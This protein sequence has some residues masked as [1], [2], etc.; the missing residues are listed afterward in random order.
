M[1][2]RSVLVDAGRLYA[3]LFRRS[4]ATTTAVY[5]PIVAIE[6]SWEEFTDGGA[7]GTLLGIVWFLALIAGP[8]VVQGALVELVDDVH[9]G[10]RPR[11]TAALLR[12]TTRRLLSLA[13]AVIAYSLAVCLGLV[14]LVVPGLY[15]LARWSLVVPAVMLEDA[16][17]GEAIDRS[18]ELVE[19]RTLRVLVV[20]LVSA[21]VEL[22]L[23]E[24]ALW[25]PVCYVESAIGSGVTY[26]AV[27]VLG[28]PY[29]AHLLNV[30]YYRLAQPGRPLLP[31]QLALR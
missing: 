7:P 19:G 26:Y 30:L 6:I 21:T 20:V 5:I 9:E 12:Q 24:L 8:L 10:S 2:P 1:S 11:P 17:A 28:A 31:E 29:V 23:P 4:I 15:V 3:L 16:T 18:S 13:G 27:L 14:L 22:A 25:I